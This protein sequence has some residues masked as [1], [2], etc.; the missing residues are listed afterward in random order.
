MTRPILLSFAFLV[1]ACGQAHPRED[2]GTPPLDAGAPPCEPPSVHVLVLTDYTPG[3]E[4]VSI[5]LELNDVII[6]GAGVRVGDDL[7]GG[8]RLGPACGVLPRSRLTV[9]ILDVRG[10]EIDA[11]V[12]LLETVEDGATMTIEVNR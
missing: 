9:R 12:L 4:V 10:A 3:T 1:A 2:A 11:A 8:V 5:V 7:S 6:D